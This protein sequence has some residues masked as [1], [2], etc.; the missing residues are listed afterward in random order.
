MR[1]CQSFTAVVENQ[2]GQETGIFCVGT[3]SPVDPVLGQNCLDLVPKSLVHEGLMLS[4]IGAA[5]VGDLTAIDAILQHEIEGAAGELVTAIDG[6]IRGRS[7][8]AAI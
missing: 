3:C 4:G 8:L 6:S 7:T 5:F 1:G 2:P